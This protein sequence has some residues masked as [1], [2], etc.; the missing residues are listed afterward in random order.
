MKHPRAPLAALTLLAGLALALPC[1]AQP[2]VQPPSV[3][4]FPV[5]PGQ[6]QPLPP[7]DPLYKLDAAGKVIRIPGSLEAIALDR[8]PLTDAATR[9]RIE[10][11]VKEWTADLNELAV[12]NVDFMEK[13]DAGLIERTSPTDVNQAR[14]VQTIINHLASAGPLSGRL[15]LKGL[16]DARQSQM[17]MQ[18]S[19]EYVQAVA[20]ELTSGAQ[21]LLPGQNQV[22]MQQAVSLAIN[23]WYQSLPARD[24]REQYR[25]ILV[26]SAPMVDQ[27]VPKLGLSAEAQARIK[28]EVAAVKA[29]ASEEDRLV[30]V[31][32]LLDDLTFDQRRTYLGKAVE[33]G[34]APDPFHPAPLF[35]SAL[36]APGAYTPQPTSGTS[37]AATDAGKK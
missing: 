35:P 15:V 26:D 21:Q 8:S 14:T 17:M 18:M 22:Q 29:A 4:K 34:A 28:P 13:L 3:K 2:G 16:I 11:V 10:P 25:R 23:R 20:T 33:L 19:N 31:R 36:P 27:L 32:L 9:E 24:V 12:D 30:A 6:P 1:S 37:S 7:H 5:P